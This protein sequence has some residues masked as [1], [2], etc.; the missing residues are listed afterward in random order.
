MFNTTCFLS[1]MLTLLAVGQPARE[2]PFKIPT[3][4]GW[5]KESI[6][7]PPSFAKNMKWKGIEELRFAPG[8]FKSDAADFFSYALLFWLPDDQKI[9][10]KA[11][12]KELLEYYRGLAKAV[13]EN[14]KLE[15]DVS[16]FTL[17]IKDEK[18]KPA[19]RTG[20][21]EVTAYVGELKWTEPFATG[22]SQTLRM[23]IQTWHS[24]KQKHHCVFI[25]ASPQPETGEIWKA[26][27]EIRVGC[28]T[29]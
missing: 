25:C 21:E 15:V 8:M 5:A 10:T 27:R 16:T 7:L 29:P 3:P 12:E 26:L 4:K 13:S 22:K 28:T 1:V 17:T 14:K 11:M 19:K 6:E 24:D 2:P 9:D 23:E 18:E 20:G